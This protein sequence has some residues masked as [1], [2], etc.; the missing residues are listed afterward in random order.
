[1]CKK[2]KIIPEM[3]TNLAGGTFYDFILT[4]QVIDI[5]HRHE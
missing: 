2:K 3:V 5:L 1:M 4:L